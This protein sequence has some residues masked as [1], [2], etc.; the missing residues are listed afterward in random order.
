[1]S[2]MRFLSPR[3][4]D[5]ANRAL[6][7]LKDWGGAMPKTVGTGPCQEVVVQGDELEQRPPQQGSTIDR[8]G[9]GPSCQG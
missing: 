3:N 1:M 8:W 6:G 7:K 5:V 2:R 9:L 4:F